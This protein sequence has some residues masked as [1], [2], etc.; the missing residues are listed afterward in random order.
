MLKIHTPF[1]YEIRRDSISDCE[2]EKIGHLCGENGESDAGSETYN[3]GVRNEFYDRSESE[4]SHNNQDTAGHKSSHC[5]PCEAVKLNDI[6]DN[7]DEST[8]RSSYLHRVST[9][10]GDQKSSDDGS[11]QADS[12]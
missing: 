2:S 10:S 3:N 1:P 8:G 9:E 6:E 5:E 12:R 4:D 11:N 7:N